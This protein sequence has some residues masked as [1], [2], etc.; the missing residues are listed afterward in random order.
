LCLA[1]IGISVIKLNQ[2][3]SR[4]PALA[5]SASALQIVRGQQCTLQ[6]FATNTDSL[7]L[8]GELVPN[9]GSRAVSPAE[10]TTYRLVASG[11]GGKSESREV[12]V[13]VTEPPAA[14]TIQFTGDRDHIITSQSLTLRWSVSGATRIQ[15]EPDI[16]PVDAQGEHTVSPEQPTEYIIT[17]DGPGGKTTDR[18]RVQVNA[19][20][21][22]VPKIEA[23]EAAPA[24]SI[25]QCQMVVLRWTVHGASRISIEPGLGEIVGKQDWRPVWPLRTTT[26]VLTAKGAGGS[27]SKDVTIHVA[28]GNRSN[29]GQ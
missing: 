4:R 16:G 7:R 19:P 25:Q 24:T 10:T 26:Y 22:K 2:E 28:R 6:W 11:R 5:L 1:A 18:F 9:S 21:R 14:P 23:F 3:K 27:A 20:P 17:A 12:T 8:N 13:Q 15:I 29:C